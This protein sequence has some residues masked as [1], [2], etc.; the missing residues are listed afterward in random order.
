M[1]DSKQTLVQA[2]IKRQVRAALADT[3][4]YDT[5][6]EY[7]KVVK[8]HHDRFEREIAYAVTSEYGFV[9]LADIMG[10][11]RTRVRR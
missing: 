8:K 3:L 5:D 4:L 9:E 2:F 7:V 1:A 10:W 11:K 6:E